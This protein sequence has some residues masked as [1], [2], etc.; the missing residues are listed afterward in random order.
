ME[1]KKK[2]LQKYLHAIAVEQLAEEYQQNGYE[3]SKEKEINKYTADLIAKKGKEMVVIEVKS[4]R[5]T[6]EKKDTIKEIGNY[7]KNK[8]NYKFLVVIAT[9]PKEK[10]LEISNIQ[11]L[12]S[13]HILDDFPD[14]LLELSTHTTFDGISDIEIDEI[15]IIDTELFVSGTGVVSVELQYGSNGDQERGDGFKTTDSFPF[16]FKMTLEFNKNKILEIVE[17]ERFEVDNSSF[18]GKE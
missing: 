6:S 15:I 10:K 11:D 13:D 4:G 7:V 3:V 2:Y 18:Y 14:E 1:I 9:P 8:A 17:V 12:L 16:E 5:L